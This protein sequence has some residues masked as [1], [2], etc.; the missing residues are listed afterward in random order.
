MIKKMIANKPFFWLLLFPLLV[1]LNVTMLCCLLA[2][3][4]VPHMV[5]LAQI[6]GNGG[7]LAVLGVAVGYIIVKEVGREQQ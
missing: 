2:V 1:V 3:L 7:T 6:I 4:D 5:G